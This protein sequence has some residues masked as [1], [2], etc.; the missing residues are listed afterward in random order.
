MPSNVARFEKLMYLSLGISVILSIRRWYAGDLTG[1]TFLGPAFNLVFF[2][3]F[4]WLAARRRK[5]WARWIL[6]LAFIASMDVVVEVLLPIWRTEGLD[7]TLGLSSQ[8]LAQLIALIFIFTGNAR[9]WFRQS[10]A[11][12]HSTEQSALP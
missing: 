8:L 12:V 1:A 7:S 11:G 5:N 9:A 4:I 6:L 2:V 10:T 3:L